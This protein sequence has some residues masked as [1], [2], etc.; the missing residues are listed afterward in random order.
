MKWDSIKMAQKFLQQANGLHPEEAKHEGR[1]EEVLA[2]QELYDECYMSS[3]SRDKLTEFLKQAVAGKISRSQSGDESEEP[4]LELDEEKYRE[5][6]AQLAN[7]ILSD[8]E[9]ME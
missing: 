1:F 9:K 3:F 7:K 5:A 6:Y 8:V 4:I 2:H